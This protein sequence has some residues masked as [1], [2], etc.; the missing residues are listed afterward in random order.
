MTSS[1]LVEGLR[2]IEIA[3]G[4]AALLAGAILADHGAEVFH[5]TE[6]GATPPQ[7]WPVRGRNK[8]SVALQTSSPSG[9]ALLTRL[10]RAVDVLVTDR[11]VPEADGDGV[12]S[13]I[14]LRLSED[15]SDADA[16]ARSGVA[17]LT[18]AAGAD[19]GYAGFEVAAGL[20]AL[21]GVLGISAALH[22]RD[23]TPGR[24]G[25]RIDLATFETPF[26]MVDTQVIGYDQL[27]LVPHRS[28]N[29]PAFGADLNDTYLTVDDVW[30]IV[31][32]GTAKAIDALG[33]LLGGE[34]TPDAVRRWT[35]ARTAVDAEASLGL[36]GVPAS[37]VLTIDDVIADPIVAA[38]GSVVRMGDRT[39]PS[40]LP[41]LR[42]H[43][44]SVRWVGRSPGEDTD[45]ALRT[46][47]DLDDAALSRL[48][49]E[50]VLP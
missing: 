4:S 50:G 13:L 2:V 40:V 30:I 8:L 22:H 25:E 36:A 17:H 16:Q 45:A 24:P 20:T 18:G 47:L 12:P 37:R 48:R 7:T 6:P 5:V 31:S 14:V 29:H 26:R 49:R 28:G 41:H 23:S 27:Q 9:G 39:M 11:A 43:R 34:P 35:A 42:N 1:S 32:A 21:M 3:S 46:L 10:L 15:A 33:A 38:R 19:P 44:G